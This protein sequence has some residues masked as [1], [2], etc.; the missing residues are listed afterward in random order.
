MI[1]GSVKQTMHGIYTRCSTRYGQVYIPQNSGQQ[2]YDV[3]VYIICM[4]VDYWVARGNKHAN[5]S[6]F[7][8]GAAAATAAAEVNV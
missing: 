1:P 7:R 8:G 6:E 4:C 2:E 5:A 3:H